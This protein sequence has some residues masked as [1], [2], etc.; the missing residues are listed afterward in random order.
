MIGM[1]R[2][3]AVCPLLALSAACSDPGPID[4]G[5]PA[6]LFGPKCCGQFEIT[7]GETRL[8]L[9]GTAYSH[10]ADGRSRLYIQFGV[11]PPG[12]RSAYFSFVYDQAP[13]APGVYSDP[14][15]GR[16][17]F[18]TE[19]GKRYLFEAGPGRG[20]Y[21]LV[22]EAAPAPSGGEPSHYLT[23]KIVLRL[24]EDGRLGDTQAYVSLTVNAETGP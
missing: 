14:K 19:G 7:P 10:S 24:E 21:L 3:F 12:L 1:S 9:E 17:E 16:A 4:P 2:T 8:I 15:A 18:V 11:L 23:G 13:W 5:P 20:F 22:K 6:L